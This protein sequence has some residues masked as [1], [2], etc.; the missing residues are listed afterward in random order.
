LAILVAFVSFALGVSFLC[1]LLEAA[2]LSVQTATLAEQ[3]D[4]GRRG[5]AR[6]LVLKQR[7][8]D[9]AISAIL[10]L[11]TLANTLGATLAGAQ[12]ARVFGS[13]W[14]GLFSGVLTL[15]ILVLSEI[16]PKTLGALY[17]AP[18][19]GF[20]GNTLYLLTRAMAPA[21]SLS[22]HL[23]RL[24]AREKQPGMSR[25]EL[26]A[27]IATA[28][29]EGA[30][31]GHE[32][33][34]FANLLSFEKVRVEDVMTPRIVMLS[35]PATATVAEL[36]A[37]PGADAFSR[38]PLYRD[39]PDNIVGYVLQRDVLAQAARGGGT[40]RTLEDYLRAIRYIPETVSVGVALRQFLQGHEALAM[41]ADEHGGVAGLVTLEDLTETVLGAE[42][43][44]ESDTV[45]DLRKAALD[46]RQRRI[47]RL[48]RR[49]GLAPDDEPD[50]G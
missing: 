28:S 23:T 12:A 18:L 22:G 2:F 38:I 31:S 47:E 46:A 45:V 41:V 36:L 20:V 13:A 21:L 29:S 10:I 14:V 17:A 8:V 43:V 40:S 15:L 24:L 11:N 19:S 50:G 25:G 9:E 44:D 33:A 30:I 3:R 34:L 5:A 26:S 7:R 4:A 48:R 16:I 37:T 32:S 42:I 49:R 6:L 35:L 39:E 1:S 27:L